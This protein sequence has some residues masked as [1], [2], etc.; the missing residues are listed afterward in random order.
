MRAALSCGHRRG[1]RARWWGLLALAL[2]LAL[3]A[4]AGESIWD[5][6]PLVG[7]EQEELSLS[8]RADGGPTGWSAHD[9]QGAAI[10]LHGDQQTLCFSLTPAAVGEVKVLLANSDRHIAIDFVH[11]GAGAELALDAQGRLHRGQDL[12][13]LVLP[14]LEAQADRRWAVLGLLERPAGQPCSVSVEEPAVGWG[15]PA[16]TAQIC[17]SQ[18][19][20][21]KSAGVLVRLSGA[22]RLAGWKHRE[23]RQ[24]LAWLV[25]DLLAR[26]AERVVLVEPVAPAA[27]AA[28][29]QPLRVQIADV[30]RAYHC[31]VVETAALGRDADWE[32]ADGVLGT[33]LNARGQ[34]AFAELLRPYLHQP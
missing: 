11:P 26:G 33:T 3:P 22:D 15:E 5:Y 16:L 29:V 28:V 25:A 32:V 13:V 10:A 1:S 14:R 2:V 18:H 27:E 24:A 23:Y 20:Q 19:L 21:P 30:G 12:A 9:A 4:Q 7:Y 34:A 8:L 31:R 6:L 17:A